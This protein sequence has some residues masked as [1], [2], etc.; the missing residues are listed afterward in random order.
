MKVKEIE[1]VEE[2]IELLD[3][4]DKV[5]ID[6]Y[7]DWCGPCKLVEP[8][9]KKLAEEVKDVE[10]VK[11]NIDKVK[12][13][14]SYF[15]IRAIPTFVMIVNKKYSMTVGARD[16]KSLKAWIEDIINKVSRQ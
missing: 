13:L 2:F 6:F 1:S 16:R 3:K 7:A 9:V 10:F 14:A 4:K 8:E 5:F 11:V 12:E 15:N